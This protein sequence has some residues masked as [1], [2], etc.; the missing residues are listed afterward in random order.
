MTTIS[1]L[2]DLL[3]FFGY[4]YFIRERWVYYRGKRTMYG[5]HR[6]QSGV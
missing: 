6:L 2:Q 1:Y 5:Y 4:F 3:V